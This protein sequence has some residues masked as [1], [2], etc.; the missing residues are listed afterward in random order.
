MFALVRIDCPTQGYHD[1]LT[2]QLRKG[3]PVAQALA[4]CGIYVAFNEKKPRAVNARVTNA[5]GFA[6]RQ[7]MRQP[8][9]ALRY[10]G[11]VC[12]GFVDFFLRVLVVG[13][14]AGEILFVGGHVEEAV[15]A[16]V[17][18]DGSFFAFFFRFQRLIDG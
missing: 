7:R 18:Q 4:A 16:E 12:Q 8:E 3:R 17:E 5:G 14:F 10:L 15:A 2:G 9:Q 6:D 13:E 11:Q 1:A